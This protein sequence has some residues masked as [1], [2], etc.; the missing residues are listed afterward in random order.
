MLCYSAAHPINRC[1]KEIPHSAALLMP[2]LCG[3]AMISCVC[4]SFAARS[5]YLASAPNSGTPLI[6]V[7]MPANTP[8]IT[9]DAA[10]RGA[11]I[12]AMFI[13]ADARR[14]VPPSA[15]VWGSPIGESAVWVSG[16]P[17]EPPAES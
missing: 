16:G 5:G 7:T 11:D 12:R 17:G 4:L 2:R 6:A 3:M 14:G 9:T 8:R 1:H 15:W 10:K 13:G